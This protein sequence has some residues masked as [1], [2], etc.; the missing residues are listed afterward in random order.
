MRALLLA[1]CAVLLASSASARRHDPEKLPV[2]RI[3]DLHYGDALFYYYQDKEF[4]ALTRLLAYDHWNRL[5]HHADEAQL[6]MGSLYLQ[7]GMHNEAG[8]LF[9]R[10]LTN[11]TAPGSTWRRCGTRAVTSTRPKVPC[12]G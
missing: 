5:P 11:A 8:E 12:A 6:L 7:L 3:R 1:A 2:T 9:E 4:D 10:L